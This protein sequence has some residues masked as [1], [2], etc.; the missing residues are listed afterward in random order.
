MKQLTTSLSHLVNWVQMT[1]T[2]SPLLD[3]EADSLLARLEQLSERHRRISA[4]WC[5]RRWRRW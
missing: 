5:W 2:F 4:R 1:R 3:N